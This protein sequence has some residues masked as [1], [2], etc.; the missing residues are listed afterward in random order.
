MSSTQRVKE[1]L[2]QNKWMGA[3]AAFVWFIGFLILITNKEPIRAHR[4]EGSDEYYHGMMTGL[5]SVPC[6]L[7][8]GMVIG[9]MFASLTNNR[10][11]PTETE[12]SDVSSLASTTS[13]SNQ[14]TSRNSLDE[15]IGITFEL[16]IEAGS[17]AD[18]S[19][20]SSELESNLSPTS[21]SRPAFN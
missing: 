20:L 21:S 16:D 9:S 2:R 5:V 8:L 13:T 17:S 4:N 14:D 11:S 1:L 15:R 12:E 18:V 19:S 10:L 3:G 6:M 7:L